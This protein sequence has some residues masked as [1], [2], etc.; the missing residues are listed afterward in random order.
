MSILD[1]VS[2]FSLDIGGIHGAWL[3]Q[4]H[5]ETTVVSLLW[6]LQHVLLDDPWGSPDAACTVASQLPPEDTR[7]YTSLQKHVV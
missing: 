5:A 3:G 7:G 2:E 6:G 4:R 1:A